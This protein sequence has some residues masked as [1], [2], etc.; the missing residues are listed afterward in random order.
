VTSVLPVERSDLPDDSDAGFFAVLLA[1][2]DDLL[3]PITTNIAQDKTAI[4]F[5]RFFIVL[6]SSL[7]GTL[8]S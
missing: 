3:Q 7:L 6:S 4:A 1:L 2:S 5:K 8:N